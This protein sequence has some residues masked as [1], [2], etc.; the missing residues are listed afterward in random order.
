MKNG[1]SDDRSWFYFIPVS[2]YSDLICV[3][4]LILPLLSLNP[5]IALCSAGYRA[6]K[7][8]LS[9]PFDCCALFTLERENKIMRQ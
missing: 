9:N 3:L 7:P 8:S 1:V 5:F 4:S 2:R 6:K